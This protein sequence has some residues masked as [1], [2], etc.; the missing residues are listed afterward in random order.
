MCGIINAITLASAYNG[1]MVVGERCDHDQH[2]LLLASQACAALFL[3]RGSEEVRAEFF[4][5][6][7]V[8][9]SS[10][11]VMCGRYIHDI[12]SWCNKAMLTQMNP[13]TPPIIACKSSSHHNYCILI[14]DHAK[15]VLLT[16]MACVEHSS[17]SSKTCSKSVIW[18]RPLIRRFIAFISEIDGSNEAC[19][20]WYVEEFT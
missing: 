20:C 7:A 4:R 14:V 18:C 17:S 8:S 5:V 6:L 16:S 19:F 12:H 13:P 3:F 15:P 10:S 11:I 2:W 1:S 9:G